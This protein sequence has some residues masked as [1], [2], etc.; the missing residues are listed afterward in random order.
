M[1]HDMTPAI[2]INY[3]S[4]VSSDICVKMIIREDSVY[5]I[6]YTGS[7]MGVRLT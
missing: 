2:Q 5:A 3:I 7:T 6:H 4:V 1:E